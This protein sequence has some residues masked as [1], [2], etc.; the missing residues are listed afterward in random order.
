MCDLITSTVFDANLK[1]EDLR[2][3]GL[4]LPGAVNPETLQMLNGNTQIFINRD[5]IGDLK[6]I[7][8]FKGKFN[9]ANDANCFALAEYKLGA[10]LLHSLETK[11]KLSSPE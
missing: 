5:L 10:G 8:N 11:T 4:G 7:I 9:C 1:L 2:G 3:I 6:K